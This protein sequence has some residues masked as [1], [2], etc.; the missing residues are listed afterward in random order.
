MASYRKRGNKWSVEICKNGVR[1]SAT[2]PTK[3]E[4]KQWAAEK[5]ADLHLSNSKLEVTNKRVRDAFIRY[6]DEVSPLKKGSRWEIVRIN[7]LLKGSLADIKLSLIKPSDIADW[8]DSRITE[9]SAS[10]VNRELNLISSIFTRARMEWQWLASNPVHDIKR[11]SNPK[12]RDVRIDDATIQR[13]TDSLGYDGDIEIKIHLVAV[14]FLIAIETA[15]RLDE[16]CSLAKEDIRL[17]EKFVIIRDSKNSDSRHVPLSSR[18]VE[19]F[20]QVK[21]SELSV[22]ADTASTLFRRYKNKIGLTHIHFHDARH[23][24]LTR[25]A[26]KVDVLDLAR[27]VGHRDVKSLMIYYNASATEIAERLG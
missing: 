19:L 20:K 7:K 13:I 26:R 4:A 2:F 18:A 24:A 5:E 21:G 10:S 17:E 16:I 12:P 23:E 11:P 6:R 3:A 25:L 22:N 27:M 14:Y 1:K 15:M 9:V 8:R